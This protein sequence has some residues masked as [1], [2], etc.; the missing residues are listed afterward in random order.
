MPLYVTIVSVI[1]TVVPV[2]FWLANVI[3]GVQLMLVLLDLVH[4]VPDALP[5]VYVTVCVKLVDS[6]FTVNVWAS[7]RSPPLA[8]NHDF[9]GIVVN[10][11]DADAVTVP[12][13]TPDVYDAEHD[14][15][16]EPLSA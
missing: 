9:L 1:D 3:G 13:D 16:F 15:V 14:S 4:I 6:R 8:D 2:V 11:F 12:L 10:T 5:Q 7:P